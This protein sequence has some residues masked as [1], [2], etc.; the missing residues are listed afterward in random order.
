MVSCDSFRELVF[1]M[2]QSV[3]RD[4]F[5]IMVMNLWSTGRKRDEKIWNGKDE[6]VEMVIGI[7][8]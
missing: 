2:K 3:T 5:E 6:Q 8:E 1:E 7:V 4:Q